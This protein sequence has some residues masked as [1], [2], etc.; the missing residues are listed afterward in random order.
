MDKRTKGW[1]IGAGIAAGVVALGVGGLVIGFARYE[2][3]ARRAWKEKALPEIASRADDSEWIAGQ[4]RLLNDADAGFEQGVIGPGWLTDGMIL[5]QSGEWLV[6]KS[7]C[8]KAAPHNVRDICLAKGSDGRWYYTTC[9]FCVG[10]VA[11]VMMQE[12]QP[13]DLPYFVKRYHFRE[14]DGESDECLKETETVADDL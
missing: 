12:D 10:M 7:H 14:F 2:Q 8:S 6:Y 13:P 3:R 5:M 4:S 9:H 1:V 11:L